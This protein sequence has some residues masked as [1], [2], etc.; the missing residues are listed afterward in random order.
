MSTSEVLPRT[1]S[2]IGIPFQAVMV[3]LVA[4]IVVGLTVALATLTTTNKPVSRH[5]IAAA[6]STARAPQAAPL[7]LSSSVVRD[8]VTHALLPVATAT[9]TAP[10]TH[11]FVPV[12]VRMGGAQ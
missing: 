12:G 7:R 9:A 2:P 6:P 8:P 3:A 11:A 10:A 4:V 5:Q 1:A